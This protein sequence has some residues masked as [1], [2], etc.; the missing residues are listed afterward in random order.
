MYCYAHCDKCNI[1]FNKI[2]YIKAL[3]HD[4]HCPGCNE[5]MKI[6]PEIPRP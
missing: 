4:F 2:D 6:A 3:T 5:V 1:Y